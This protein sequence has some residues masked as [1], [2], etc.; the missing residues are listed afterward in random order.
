MQV[1]FITVI[2]EHF[3]VKTEIVFQVEHKKHLHSKHTMPL[4][5]IPLNK[6]LHLT[7]ANQ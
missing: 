3:Y 6:R 2:E 4:Q 1:N 5:M 7:G